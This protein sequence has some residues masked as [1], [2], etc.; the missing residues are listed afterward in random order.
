MPDADALDHL[1]PLRHDLENVL[2]TLAGDRG[3]EDV[4]ASFGHPL[5]SLLRDH[6]AVLVRDRAGTFVVLRRALGGWNTAALRRDDL[7]DASEL[8]DLARRELK[9]DNDDL[10]AI[11]RVLDAVPGRPTHSFRPRARLLVLL[12]DQLIRDEVLAV[13][14]LVK[15]SY[16]ADAS[17]ADLRLE[18]LSDPS[19]AQIVVVDDGTGMSLRTVT[20]VWLEPGTDNRAQ[21]R[22]RGERSPRFGRLPLGEK[23]V[24]RFAVHKLGRQIELVTRASGH[25]EVVVSIDWDEVLKERYLDDVGVRVYE[26]NAE[27]FRGDRTGTLVRI[28]GL[29]Q[30][31]KRGSVRE[32]V[33]RV[34]SIRSPF[35]G[36]S[37]FVTKITIE[38]DADWLDGLIEVDDVLEA[39]MW[40]ASMRLEDGRLS[41]IYEFDPL[42]G[43]DDRIDGRRREFADEIRFTTE[44]LQA[45]EDSPDG[46]WSRIGPVDLE[47]RMFDLDPSVLTYATSD[48]RG[49]KR[50]LAENG[51]VRVYRDGIRVFDYGSPDDD[52]LGIDQ[53]RVNRPTERVSNNILIGA[54]NLSLKD[55]PGLVEKTNR[56]GF[57]ENG[58]YRLLQSSVAF[59][60]RQIEAD[61]AIDKARL[62]DLI[63][64][65]NRRLRQPVL[66]E[67]RILRDELRARGLEEELGGHLDRVEQQF[68]EVQDRLMTAAG[69][70]L[71]LAVVVHELEKQISDL[72][73]AV[74]RDVDVEQLRALAEGLADLIDGL[75]YLTRRSGMSKERAS[76]LVGYSLGNVRYRLDHHGVTVQNTVGDETLDFEVK[77]H[78]R[79]VVATLMNLYDNAIWWLQRRGADKKRLWIATWET[80]DGRPALVVADDGPG[81][82]DPPEALVEPFLSRRPDG[83]GLGLHLAS[84]VMKTHRGRI[85]FPEPDEVKAP[86]GITGAVVALVFPEAKWIG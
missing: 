8:R 68:A 51:G 53:R 67:L 58:A 82:S 54:V 27:L 69:A 31:W 30:D 19:Q 48:R 15:N 66:D 80:G 47:L 16:D 28:T 34:N 6:E 77:C 37:D 14:E 75:G 50:F 26:R 25:P 57:V 1:D 76:K 40:R 5:G 18:Q 24:G 49:Y 22:E 21:Q 65:T 9:V 11:M 13:F 81:F 63:G 45:L 39:A 71:S 62:R 74:R 70:G 23:G 79:L 10:D 59:A 35:A 29:R 64:G 72:R 42:P 3:I 60:V 7:V 44:Q 83:M 78:R 41:Y 52:W 2:P 17:H 46:T 85:G 38:P 84:E 61:R 32:L 73:R 33:R 43:M 86:P 4:R 36:P 20:G 55:S 56:E 12:G